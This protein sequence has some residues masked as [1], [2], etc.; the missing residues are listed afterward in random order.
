MAVAAMPL[1]RWRSFRTSTRLPRE[2]DKLKF[3]SQGL[4]VGTT[5][6]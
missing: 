2:K 4:R 3:A 5:P 1:D 6:E